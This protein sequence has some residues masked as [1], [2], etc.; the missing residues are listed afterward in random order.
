MT[1][2]I[3]NPLVTVAMVTYNSSQ[4][5]R[6]AIESVLASSYTNFELIISD[7][8]STDNTWEIINEYK[9]IR[10][11]AYRN[12]INLREYPN[13][14]RCIDLA[15]GEYIIF[16]DGDDYL[17]PDS[18]HKCKE[19]FSS[20]DEAGFILASLGKQSMIF[21]TLL[22]PEYSHIIHFFIEPLFNQSLLQA[23]FKTSLL[24]ENKKFAENYISGD[25]HLF[26]KLSSIYPI[27]LIN[28]PLGWWRLHNQQ[29][30]KRLIGELGILDTISI[31][32]ELF[33]KETHLSNEQKIYINN[34]NI[35]QLLKFLIK[36]PHKININYI[37]LLLDYK[38][39][40]KILLPTY[41]TLGIK[42]P[43]IKDINRNPYNNTKSNL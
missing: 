23:C 41:Q 21:P 3:N 34:K 9:D 32:K 22:T 4:Y 29:A 43:I 15:E 37:K 14:N 7:D 27:L 35:F 26:L 19:Y 30:S 10:I 18:L 12:E 16:V 1:N 25:Y 31:H 5:V 24:K 33:D 42:T 13:R 38:Y 39:I 28:A 17:F 11:R 20:F 6:M 8:C 40:N 2:N 36:R